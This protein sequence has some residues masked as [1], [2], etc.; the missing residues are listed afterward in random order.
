MLQKIFVTANGI[1]SVTNYSYTP[2]YILQA[3]HIF[4]YR[5]QSP[6]ARNISLYMKRIGNKIRST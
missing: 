3:L 5:L 6:N 2:T 1:Y 4:K